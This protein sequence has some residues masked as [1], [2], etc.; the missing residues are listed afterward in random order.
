MAQVCGVAA[1]GAEAMKRNGPDTADAGRLSTSGWIRSKGP[2]LFEAAQRS[3]SRKAR[4]G[5]RLARSGAIERIR[6]SPETAN[7]AE[8]RR[9]TTALL[10][11]GCEVFSLTY[12]SPSMVPGHMPYV[13]TS[14]D[15]SRFMA[16]VHDFCTWFRDEAGGQFTGVTRLESRLLSR[17]QLSGNDAA[18]HTSPAG[19]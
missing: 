12:H 17:P 13:R 7:G 8:M 10:A 16:T 11:S 15:L 18:H 14:A 3:W 1:A 4:L 9:L 2:Q 19:R 6:L 5:G